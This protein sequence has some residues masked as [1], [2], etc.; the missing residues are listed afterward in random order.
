MKMDK[1][2]C[3]CYGVK[4]EDIA[5]AIKN[6]AKT[7][8]EIQEVTGAATVCGSCHEYFVNVAE[9]LLSEAQE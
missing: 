1:T 2:V 5:T 8:D 4:V 6:G 7:V 9:E 3:Y